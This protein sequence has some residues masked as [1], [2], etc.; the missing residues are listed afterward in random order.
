MARKKKKSLP[1]WIVLILLILAIAIGAV[2]FFVVL[3]GDFGRLFP[4]RDDTGGTGGTG[5]TGG[6]TAGAGA[7]SIH[8]LE[9]GNKY[10]GDCTLIKAGDTEVLIDAGSRQNSAAAIVPYVRQYCTDGV[11]EYVIATHAHQDH[12]AAFVGT[13][14]APG[15][16]ESFDCGTII[17]FSRTNA[18]SN[19]YKDYVAARDK[20]VQEGAEHYTALQCWNETDGAKKRY[21]LGEGIEMQILYQKFYEEKSSDE[22]NYSVCV[23]LTQGQEHF[24]FTGDLEKEG[25]ESLCESNTLPHCKLFKGGHHGSPTSSNDVLLEQIRP[26]YVCICCCAGSPEYTQTNDNTFPSQAMIDRV[27]RYTKY[28]Y[29]TTLA[30]DIDLANEKWGYT[31]MNGNIVVTSDADTFT[32]SGS[33]NNTLL[34]DTEWFRANRTWPSYGVQ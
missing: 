2:Y 34:K 30:T 16:F 23:L 29:V 10:A 12:I 5:D 28:I 17:D 32:V 27:A 21:E 31:S 22:N 6:G 3:D 14:S 13:K 19:I 26:E 4:K 20:E 15:V 25:E 24:L 18:T 9:L 33:N 8:F 7:L 1:V 11:L